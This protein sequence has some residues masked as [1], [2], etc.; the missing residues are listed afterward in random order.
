[1]SNP[2]G[3]AIP[4]LIRK[5]DRASSDED[6][7][8]INGV[9]QLLKAAPGQSRQSIVNIMH[10]HL[11]TDSTEYAEMQQEL[12]SLLHYHDLFEAWLT[13]NQSAV[14]HDANILMEHLKD[15][16]N[17]SAS[18]NDK[19][20]KL[21]RELSSRLENFITAWET[22]IIHHLEKNGGSLPDEALFKADSQLSQACCDAIKQ[23]KTR[24]K[25]LPDV[26]E[27]GKTMINL[28]TK[29]YL[30]TEFFKLKAAMAE[31]KSDL[32]KA[33]ETLE[34]SWLMKGGS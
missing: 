5:A 1:M 10:S 32:E 18:M 31:Q 30:H 33:M 4:W 25:G 17:A 7:E 16:L 11:N 12:K 3:I 14:H 2:V 13:L 34:R 28:F 15:S 19:S 26:Y 20:R 29:T 22:T 23:Y 27:Q 24:L 21:A 6:Y 8:R 9:I